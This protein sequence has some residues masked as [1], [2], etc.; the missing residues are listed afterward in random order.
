MRNRPYGPTLKG[1]V[2]MWPWNAR[3]IRTTA[4]STMPL[5]EEQPQ[6]EHDCMKAL[7]E[8]RGRIGSKSRNDRVARP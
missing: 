7:D 6:P 1:F 2:A 5:R 3:Q 8:Q 4:A